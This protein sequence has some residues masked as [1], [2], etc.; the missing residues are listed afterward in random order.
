MDI[1]NFTSG[2]MS[3][4]IQRLQVGYMHCSFLFDPVGGFSHQLTEAFRLPI[5]STCFWDDIFDA[6]KLIQLTI[7]KSIVKAAHIWM[8][9]ILLT[10]YGYDDWMA[11]VKFLSMLVYT[12]N[13][14]SML[15]ISTYWLS[16]HTEIFM[17]EIAGTGWYF[18]ESN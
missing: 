1:S 13:M 4:D 3:G 9:H 6:C 17:L 5:P 14:K 16:F 15:Y 7:F 2:V 8:S 10:K 11:K 18:G 12:T